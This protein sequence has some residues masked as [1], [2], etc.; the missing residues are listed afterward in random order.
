MR[1]TILTWSLV[2]A[3]AFAAATATA[4]EAAPNAETA[5]AQETE[6]AE[7]KAAP[8]PLPAQTERSAAT[9]SKA[10]PKTLFE[11][12]DLVEQG[13]EIETEE[14]R[15]REQRFVQAKQDQERLLAEGK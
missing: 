4:Q 15:R 11:L 7:E 14:N 3:G 5:A 10:E 2:V 8:S 1:I 6:P 9:S 13:L 12:L